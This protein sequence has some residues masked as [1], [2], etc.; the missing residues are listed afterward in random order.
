[1]RWIY[2]SP[3]FDDAVLSCGGLIREQSR[4]GLPVEI[5]TLCAG[6]APAGPLS[7]L[8]MACHQQWGL[9][10][11]EAVVA[12][13][14]LENQAAAA[15]LGA[16]TVD[17]SIPDCIYRRSPAG[18]LLYTE[19]VFGPIH[20]LDGELDADIAAALTSELQ[21]GDIVVSPLSI[22]A[23]L[24]HVLAR[25][26][27]EKLDRPLI[28]YADIPYLLNAPESLASAAAGLK[29]T[30]HPVSAQGLEAWQNGIAAYA[31]QVPM[32]FE[33][34]EKMQAAIRLYWEDRRGV[35]LWD[36]V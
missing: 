33:T 31:S 27:A 18:E 2:I 30:L 34:S 20:P 14:R 8:S 7:A 19:E 4:K 17:F 23:H 28:Y 24:D 29:E 21:P 25:R 35:C 11:A 1:M 3:H 15:L 16:E 6:D 32:L 22:G 5:W 12:A 10:T 13:R 26:A 36:S 9:E